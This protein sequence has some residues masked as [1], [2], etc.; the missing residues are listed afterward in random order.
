MAII[1]IELNTDNREFTVNM[2]GQPMTNFKSVFV[3][4]FVNSDGTRDVSLSITQE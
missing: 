4:A 2:D 3:D 1:G